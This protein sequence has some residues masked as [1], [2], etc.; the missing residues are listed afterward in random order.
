VRGPAAGPI[1]LAAMGLMAAAKAFYTPAANS[2][3]P[4]L[5]DPP[6]LPAAMAVAGSTWGVMAVLGSSLGGVISAWLSPYVCFGLVA[7]ALAGAA[8]LS[9]G[10]RRPTQESIPTTPRPAFAAIG[11][12]LTYLRAKPKLMALVTVKSAVG[13][14]NGL[15][16]TF[17]LIAL[18]FG[19]GPLGLGLLFMVRGA[20]VA[21]GPVLFRRA[22][23][24]PAWLLPGLA[25]SMSAYSLAY[26]GVAVAHW[27]PLVLL[28]V[29]IAHAAGGGNW[30]MSNF[31]LQQLVPDELRG[32]VN[33]TDTMVA[34][35]AVTAS[36]LVVGVFV[37]SV[38]WR[39]LVGSCALTTL[40]Y[41]I[42]WRLVT[43]RL[44]RPELGLA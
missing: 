36:Q 6:D 28:G 12:A 41:A 7:V 26:L 33:A 4:N 39:V 22:L 5:V 42:G 25:L 30:V 20:G 13:V 31:A 43:R 21:L 16:V 29:F 15:L 32:R 38:D 35:I 24:R 17:P 34:M 11:E 1:A 9:G 40:T 37:D 27:F 44:D 8:M 23:N 10:I 14:G 3:L 19:A 2:S 18:S